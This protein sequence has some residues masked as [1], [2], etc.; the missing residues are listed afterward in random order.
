MNDFKSLSD[1]TKLKSRVNDDTVI[2]SKNVIPTG[3][4][5]TRKDVDKFV[6]KLKEKKVI[7][8]QKEKE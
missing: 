4:E 7:D 5:V 3:R 1:E 8:K 6:K 2:S